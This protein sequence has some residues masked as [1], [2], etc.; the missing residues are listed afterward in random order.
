MFLALRQQIPSRSLPQRLQRIQLLVEPLGSQTNSGFY[1]LGQ[2][3]RTMAPSVR[4]GFINIYSSKRITV[5]SQGRRA[6]P[7]DA[8][9][10]PP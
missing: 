3:F 6:S 1:N 5:Q 7:V 2:P 9:G 8:V 4:S 10:D